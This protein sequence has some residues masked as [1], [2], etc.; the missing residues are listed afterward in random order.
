MLVLVVLDIGLFANLNNLEMFSE[1][2]GARLLF[3]PKWK[4]EF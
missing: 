3:K 1:Q 4:F 2:F